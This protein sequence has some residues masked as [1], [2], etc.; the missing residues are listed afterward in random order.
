[1]AV[2]SQLALLVS[3]DEGLRRISIPAGRRRVTIG[4]AKKC[5]LVLD[6]G[7]VSREHAAIYTGVRLALEDLGSSNGTWLLGRRM[8]AHEKAQLPLGAAF[9]L[10]ES[11]ML[12]HD[13]R[14][15][16]RLKPSS[17][18]AAKAGPVVAD[19][20]SL[21]LYGFLQVIAPSPLDV[22]LVGDTGTGKRTY[23]HALV[24]RSPLA[25]KPLVTVDCGTLDHA[26]LGAAREEAGSG[27]L[28][29]E[30]VDELPD[31]LRS[32]VLGPRRGGPRRIFT[33]RAAGPRLATE[34]SGFALAMPPLRMRREDILPLARL[35]VERSAKQLH[36]R[37][38]ELSE[39]AANALTRHEWPRNVR[40]L[41][42]V[43]DRAVLDADGAEW[44][45]LEH[46]RL[47]RYE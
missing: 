17:G 33:A 27:T 32:K 37:T 26:Q 6:D 38:P 45:D 10:A 25:K 20:R 3:A 16:P 5:D 24:A 19:P 43:I 44:I 36:E 41:E 31:S 11:T 47:P 13:R 1:M 14:K 23:A 42:S 39:Q 4:R 7:S 8:D 2:L 35:F 22:L 28:L 40:E 18:R 30:R 21:R 46:L 34:I 12:V 9:D 29:F 15:I